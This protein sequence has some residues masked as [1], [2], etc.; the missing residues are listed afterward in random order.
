MSDR[1]RGPYAK[2]ARR[3]DD[4]LDA[5]RSVFADRGYHGGSLREIAE[6]AGLSEAGVLHHFPGKAALLEAVLAR[7]DEVALGIVPF[8]DQSAEASIRGLI[9]LARWNAS[10]AAGIELYCVLSAEATKPSHPAHDYFVRRYERVR[11]IFTDA[12]A[13]LSERGLVRQGVSPEVAARSVMA[14]MD[15]LQLQWLLDRDSVDM[16]D[17]IE[18]FLSDLVLFD[19]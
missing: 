16:A 1:R 5:A 4:I 3:R 19:I 15:G 12:F 14:V 18:V 2:T 6:R 11:R 9:E 8:G 7:G 13:E 17:V 10:E